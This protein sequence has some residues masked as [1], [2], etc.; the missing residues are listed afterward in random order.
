MTTAAAMHAT[1]AHKT[2]T[3]RKSTRLN[4]SHLG[5]SDAVFC[6]KKKPSTRPS[7]KPSR[8]NSN[9]DKRLPIA[10]RANQAGCRNIYRGDMENLGSLVFFKDCGPPLYS[11]PFPASGLPN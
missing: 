7:T 3:D 8:A 11:P 5:I 9:R 1:A 4:S 2:T 6:L 10:T